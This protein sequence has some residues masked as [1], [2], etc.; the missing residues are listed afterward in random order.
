[1]KFLIHIILLFF[2][3]DLFGQINEAAYS[4]FTRTQIGINASFDVGYRQLKNSGGSSLGDYIIEY[5][6][7]EEIPKIGFTPG[8]N[9]LFNLKNNMSVEVGIQYSNKGFQTKMLELFPFQ[10]N[11]P[12]VPNETK[13]IYNYHYLD[14]PLRFNYV[15]GKKKIRFLTSAGVTTNVFIEETQKSIRIYSD[16]TEKNTEPTNIEYNRFNIT[17]TLSFGI[18]YKINNKMNL[19]IEPIFRYGILKIIDA[20]ITG[21]L[22]NTGLNVGF[23]FGV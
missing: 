14:I 23:Y 16:R 5:R 7:N 2:T 15:F 6:N 10:P 12:L 1:M 13:F 22:Y 19:R 21:Y 4:D 9:T 20:P 8:L 11:D 17:P 18:D 3:F